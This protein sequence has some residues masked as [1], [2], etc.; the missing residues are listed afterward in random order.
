MKKYNK[1]LR[2]VKSISTVTLGLVLIISVVD[3]TFAAKRDKEYVAKQ[4]SNLKIDGD[5]RE[6]ERAEAVAFDQYK[7]CWSGTARSK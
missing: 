6:W 3:L 5:I 2:T 1:F 4:I 7:G